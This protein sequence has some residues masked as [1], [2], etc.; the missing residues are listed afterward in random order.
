M[1][2][3]ILQHV[4]FEKPG[5][6]DELEPTVIKIFENNP[7]LPN[8]DDIEFLIILG[9]PM[10]ENDFSN[11]PPTYTTVGAVGA[12]DPFRDETINYVKA[13]TSANVPVEFH[14]YPGCFHEFEA[15]VPNSYIS[16]KAIEESIVALKRGLLS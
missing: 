11:L 2:T 14:L 3:Y 16:N 5:I 10:R 8:V 15:M 6:L 12:L 9:G 13:L 4:P 7:Q 1:K